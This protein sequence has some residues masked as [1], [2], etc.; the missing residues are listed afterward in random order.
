MIMQEIQCYHV[1][2]H[3]YA[4]TCT[5]VKVTK[6]YENGEKRERETTNIIIIT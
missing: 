2:Q 3:K 4:C 1:Q 5:C 6:S